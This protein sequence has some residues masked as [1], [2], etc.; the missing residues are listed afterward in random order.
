MRSIPK[1]GAHDLPS[2]PLAGGA[3]TSIPYAV[4]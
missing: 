2:T 3:K 4:S 1:A